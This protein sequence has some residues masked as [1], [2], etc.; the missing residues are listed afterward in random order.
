MTLYFMRQTFQFENSI[1]IEILR[2]PIK[3]HNYNGLFIFD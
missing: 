3:S 2:N 1:L